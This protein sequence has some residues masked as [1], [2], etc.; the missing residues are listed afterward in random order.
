MLIRCKQR[1]H[2]AFRSNVCH[3]AACDEA[4]YFEQNCAIRCVQVPLGSICGASDFHFNWHVHACG[5]AD[6]HKTAMRKRPDAISAATKR[7]TESAIEHSDTYL[8]ICMCVGETHPFC[9]SVTCSVSTTLCTR[10]F[11]RLGGE[12]GAKCAI[13]THT[14]S[15]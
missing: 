13:H 2:V 14:C 3:N 5:Y 1:D 9:A 7:R 10:K 15:G 12:G 4:N 8:H 6:E 11:A